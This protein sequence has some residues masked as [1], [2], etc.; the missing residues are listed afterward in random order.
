MEQHTREYFDKGIANILEKMATKDD[1]AKLK[2]E[3]VTKADL[4]VQLEAQTSELKKYV[5]ESFETQQ[6]WMDERFKEQI[7]NYDVR[8]RVGKLEKD[9]AKLK[10]SRSQV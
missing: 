9:V 6:I 4:K 1:L 2:A 3:M 10:L 8:E 5:A 7:E